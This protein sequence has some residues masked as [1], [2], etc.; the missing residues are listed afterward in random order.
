M[1][2]L[3]C[4]LLCLMLPFAAMSESAAP[5]TDEDFTLLIGE[6][7]C[8]LGEEPA[9]LVAAL[10]ALTGEP[11]TITESVSCMFDGTDREFENEAAVVGTYPIGPDGGDAVESVIVFTDAIGTVRG[12]TV[13]MTKA[14][15]EALY[16]ADY[17]LDWDQMVY[18]AGEW[19]PQLIFI[20]DLET[21]TVVGW[22]LLRNT[23]A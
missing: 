4:L 18:S 6:T 12:A 19:E 16:G 8:A 17:F 15:I 11:L 5:L 10:E 23:V 22:M 7:V 3:A 2:K 9:D 13:G 21:E 20:L 1:K 14:D